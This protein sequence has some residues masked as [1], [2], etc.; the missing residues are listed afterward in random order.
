[1][2]IEY[3]D[4]KKAVVKSQHCQRNWD[5]SKG[6]LQEDLDLLVHAVT[7]CPSKQNI[8]HYKVHFIT[9]R[10]VIEEIHKNTAGFTNYAQSP[11]VDETNSQVLA[12]L[13]IAFEAYD[14][15]LALPDTVFRNDE[16]KDWL[17]NNALTSQQ[18][19]VMTRD[20]HMAVGIAAG[21]VNVIS[22]M[23]GYSTGCCACFDTDKVK[24]II[25][26]DNEILLLMGVG[27]PDTTRNRREHHSTDF[28]FPTKKKQPIIVNHIS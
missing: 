8:A 4:I 5:L 18:E 6:I 11:A 27:Y 15:R 3:K 26:A 10:E 21:Y 12:N 25:N 23:I 2:E 14:F 13:L 1:M 7:N 22:S 16:T 17:D 19:A 28:V 9:D 24:N 20:R